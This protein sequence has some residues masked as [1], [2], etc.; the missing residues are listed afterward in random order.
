ME[1]NMKKRLYN[2]QYADSDN[3]A[4]NT[5]SK[6]EYPN[7]CPLGNVSVMAQSKYTLIEDSDAHEGKK[8]FAVFYCPN[9]EGCFLGEYRLGK[10]SESYL[11]GFEPKKIV[12]QKVFP[13]NIQEIS[14]RFCTIYNQAYEAQQRGLNEICGIGF[15]K[16]LEFLVKDYAI[17]LHPEQKSIIETQFLM[18][19]I[20][21]YIDDEK[22]KS[23]AKASAW[24]GNDE[25]HY[26]KR[27]PDYDI[28]KLLSFMNTMVTF[29]DYE[30]NFTKSKAL[31][32]G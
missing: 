21:E 13:Q 12:E 17:S 29:I 18:Q 1:K 20:S 23:L 27:H 28:D 14:K 30:I 19:T 25:T 22:I 5:E 26:V 3:R 8:V 6:Y 31:L 16:A 10:N 11:T 9:C 7:I 2:V 32:N 15:R 24:L 4:L